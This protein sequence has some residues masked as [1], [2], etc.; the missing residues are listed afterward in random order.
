MFSHL[1]INAIVVYIAFIVFCFTSFF[2]S[3]LIIKYVRGN[4][5]LRLI[6]VV[7]C[8]SP[9][10]LIYLFFP[11]PIFSFK[12]DTEPIIYI[13]I[14]FLILLI[15]E[16]KNIYYKF[17]RKY[18]FLF[19]RIEKKQFINI[20]AEGSLIPIIEE[21]FFRGTIPIH[22]NSNIHI[23]IFIIISIML[24][25][26]I[27][28]LGNDKSKIYHI[29]LFIFNI[30]TVFLYLKFQNITYCILFHILYN[31]IHVITC[32]ALYANQNRR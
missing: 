14:F 7:F 2:I 10:L 28:Y 29:K 11:L 15:M 16:F 22:S 30:F 18:S 3:K 12:I 8:F 19:H 5:L 31:S 13:V 32:V 6:R 17:Q 23:T 25:H 1:T 27:H 21:L 24:F 4:V 20:V 26:Y 9:Y